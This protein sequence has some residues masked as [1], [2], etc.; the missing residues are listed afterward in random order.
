MVKRL[1][2]IVLLAL[3]AL[4]LT[5]GAAP[6]TGQGSLNSYDEWIPG[7]ALGVMRFSD[8]K[9]ELGGWSS[10]RMAATY[11]RGPAHD[12][13]KR[14]K[15]GLKLKDRMRG[16]GDAVGFEVSLKNLI[17]AVGHE[18]AIAVYELS[19][20]QFVLITRLSP[21]ERLASG[22]FLRDKGVLT[23][24]RGEH[25][26]RTLPGRGTSV[27]TAV[28]GDDLFVATDL[29]HLVAAL[30]LADGGEATSFADEIAGFPAAPAGYTVSLSLDQPRVNA[31][32]HF[33]SYWLPMNGADLGWISRT[34]TYARFEDNNVREKRLYQPLEGE[35]A[36]H[37][38]MVADWLRGRLAASGAPLYTTLNADSAS[39]AERAYLDLLLPGETRLFSSSPEREALPLAGCFVGGPMAIAFKPR[40][41][42]DGELRWSKA[43]IF[44]CAVPAQELADK[45]A[46]LMEQRLLFGKG[47]SLEAKE[48]VR[49]EGIC[50]GVTPQLFPESSLYFAG[51]GMVAV[52][53]DPSL[54]LDLADERMMISGD[55]PDSLYDLKAL[56]DSLRMEMLVLSQGPGMKG[57]SAA[58]LIGAVA[59]SLMDLFADTPRVEVRSSIDGSGILEQDVV[60]TR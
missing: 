43:M 36:P 49:A 53:S 51:E 42:A 21:T 18:S 45:T 8:L 19:D 34:L 27:H 11:L 17:D 23:S 14:S 59:P 13:F 5:T 4:S 35:N 26:I 15:L 32:P 31:L 24:M 1:T 52:S 28:V 2:M 12:R 22:F 50:F 16:L 60:F 41:D 40:V 44:E 3:M 37:P 58:K 57:S 39:D 30:D 6:A 9:S 25:E 48:V 29:P 54:A 38:P 7:G 55:N 56:S 33:K 47:A 10:S 46:K 20:L